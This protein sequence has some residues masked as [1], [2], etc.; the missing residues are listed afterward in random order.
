M[1]DES[2]RHGWVT[3]KIASVAAKQKEREKE[4]NANYYRLHSDKWN[5][6]DRVL[7][8]K[9]RPSNLVEQF[10]KRHPYSNEYSKDGILL[11]EEQWNQQLKLLEDY[12]KKYDGSAS[13][14]ASKAEQIERT[15]SRTARDYGRRKAV[16]EKKSPIKNRI[17]SMLDR[18]GMT[19]VNKL[20]KSGY[21]KAAEVVNKIVND[22]ASRLAY[23]I[24]RGLN[25]NGEYYN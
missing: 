23:P 6:R 10:K 13:S 16:E 21:T 24:K 15:R 19:L 25:Y 5:R 22:Y 8:D 20:R 4:Y 17:D 11:G 9:Y 7:S 14:M 12:D 3:S 18:V 2:L 1:Y